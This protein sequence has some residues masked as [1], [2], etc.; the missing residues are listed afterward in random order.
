MELKSKLEEDIKDIDKLLIVPKWN[1]NNDIIS[2]NN[3]IDDF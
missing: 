1:W 2:E 3:W